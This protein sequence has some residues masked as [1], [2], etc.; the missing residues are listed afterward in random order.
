MMTFLK[1]KPKLLVFNAI[2]AADFA[3]KNCTGDKMVPN[4]QVFVAFS[5]EKKINI[6]YW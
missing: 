3:A 4:K 5:K 6:A 2:R 1:K